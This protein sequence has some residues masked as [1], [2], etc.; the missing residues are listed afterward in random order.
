M[1]DFPLVQEFQPSVQ[2]Q[3]YVM[4]GEIFYSTDIFVPHLLRAKFFQQKKLLW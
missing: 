1:K 4:K 2:E 3:E